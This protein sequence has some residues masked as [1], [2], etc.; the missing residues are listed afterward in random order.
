MVSL[1][2]HAI[3]RGIEGKIIRATV[4]GFSNADK[5]NRGASRMGAALGA[6]RD[7]DRPR[8]RAAW[9]AEKGGE[10]RGIGSARGVRPGAGGRADAGDDA[11]TRIGRIGDEPGLP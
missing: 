9:G 3:R 7:M 1:L 11:K 10:T 5:H 8:A 4:G 6:A 2:T